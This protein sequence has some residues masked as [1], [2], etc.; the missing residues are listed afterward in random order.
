MSTRWIRSVFLFLC[1][2]AALSP[3]ATAQPTVSVSTPDN[4]A[5]E[6][7]LSGTSPGRFTLT[8]N[9]VNL[10]LPLTVQVS[11][12]GTAINSSDYSLIE[13]FQT[14]PAGQSTLNVDVQPIND[15]AK[16]NLETA[17]L[18]L[19]AGN[20]YTLGAVKTG[21]VTVYNDD[22][23]AC[24]TNSSQLCLRSGRFRVQLSGR[25]SYSSYTGKA[26]PLNDS[27]GGFWLF[28][29]GNVEVGVK[30]LEAPDHKSFWVY[31]GAA[32]D[33]PYKF[34]VT[35][36]ANPSLHPEY[37]SG[38]AFCGGGDTGAFL[39]SVAL[40][41]GE[42]LEEFASADG[43]GIATA[44]SWEETHQAA[45]VPNSTTSCLL[46]SRFQVRVSYKTTPFSPNL[47]ATAVPV[48]G[49]TAFFWFYSPDN[50][51]IFVKVLDGSALNS[52]YW[53]YYGSMTDVK[54]TIEIVD[55]VTLAS[56]E[57]S[58]SASGPLCGA[59]DTNAFVAP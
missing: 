15:L 59:G 51:E 6:W 26:I 43:G 39:R 46:N 3:L 53:V 42:T 1:L 34:T 19:V 58:S 32:T 25:G 40:P 7:G 5:S 4:Q 27:T 50:L 49:E 45:C 22:Y 37:L 17:I 52:R 10:V 56:K 55:M 48:T 31:H 47:P 11:L 41:P 2:L 20:N 33:V 14:F 35:D 38:A 57:Y 12:T 44:S 16:E 36:L 54:Y 23:N 24:T 29:A 8:R 30:V 9:N 28:S 21:T 18:T 13:T